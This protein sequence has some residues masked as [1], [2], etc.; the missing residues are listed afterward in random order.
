M[1]T[2]HTAHSDQANQAAVRRLIR[3]TPRSLFPCPFRHN[4][5]LQHYRL[6]S[7][8]TNVTKQKIQG[9]LP[10]IKRRTSQKSYSTHSGE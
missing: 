1:S 7:V 4:L 6:P 9:E 8:T 2:T 5:T 10:R 3:P